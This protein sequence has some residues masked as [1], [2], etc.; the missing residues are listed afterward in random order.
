[1]KILLTGSGGREQALAWKIRQST[2][3]TQLYTSGE[4]DIAAL[5]NF[6]RAKK[7]DL[8]IIGGE[9][10]LAAGLAD[11]LKEAGI[12]VFGPTKAAAQ[13][14]ASKVFAKDFMLRHDIPTARYATFAD[15]STALQHIQNINYPIV[16]KASGLAAGKGVFLPNTLNEAELILRQLLLDQTLGTAGAEII[17]EERLQGEE[18]SLLAFTDG[19]TVKLM[20]PARDHKRL[21]EDN[22]GPNTGGMGAYAPV[23]L[24]YLETLDVLR[25]LILQPAVDGLRMEDRPFIG[26]LYAGLILTATGPKV[27]EFNCRFGDP[28]TQVL[29]PLLDSDLPTIMDACATGKLAECPIHWKSGAAIC[30]VLAAKGYPQQPQKDD[31]ITGLDD[32]NENTVVFHAGTRQVDNQWLTAGG[33]VLNVVAW[34]RDLPQ[35]RKR[36]YERVNKINFSGMHYR[37][38]IGEELYD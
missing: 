2:Q 33:R 29:L 31:V 19:K 18:I 7:I 20:P 5:V 1:M 37:Q 21:Y 25:K 24:A 4:Q 22:E 12:K 17:I 38:D 34:G 10:L 15:F 8:V 23:T 26:V 27:L 28:E 9:T 6:A 3:L 32:R 35:A 30:V 11:A 16:I 36:A 13:I 14:E